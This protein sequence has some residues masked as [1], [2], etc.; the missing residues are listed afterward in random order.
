MNGK[1]DFGATKLI[2][3]LGVV[4]GAAVAIGV[5]WVVLTHGASAQLGGFAATLLALI[6]I[7]GGVGLA[8]VAAFFSIVIP[9]SVGKS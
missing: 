9:R 1:V 3:V 4:A 6:G 2:G 8:I 7:A 5:P